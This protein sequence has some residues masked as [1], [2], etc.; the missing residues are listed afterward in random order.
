MRFGERASSISNSIK[1]CASSAEDTL[2]SLNASLESISLQI[3]SLKARG[4]ERFA[5]KLITSYRALEQRRNALTATMLA[6]QQGGSATSGA[7]AM[8]TTSK[9]MDGE[10]G[11]IPREQSRFAV[12]EAS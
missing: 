1:Q 2:T 7:W 8:R 6:S 9:K 5:E 12:V 3:D 4:K 11:D 10:V